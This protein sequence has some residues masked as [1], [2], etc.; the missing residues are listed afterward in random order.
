MVTPSEHLALAV[1]RQAVSDVFSKSLAGAA[2]D[3][4]GIERLRALRFLTAEHGVW[5]DDRRFW[6]HLADVDPEALRR[7]IVDVLEGHRDIKLPNEQ[8]AYR[9]NGH[10]LARALWAREKEPVAT[11]ERPRVRSVSQ[12]PPRPFAPEQPVEELIL[13]ALRNGRETVREVGFDVPSAVIRETL[14]A[15]VARGLVEK[16]GPR[17]RLVPKTPQSPPASV[18]LDAIPTT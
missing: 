18:L 12:P 2:D 3:A 7:N 11:T 13:D 16:D 10:D 6:C 4:Q 14:D 5:A 17:Y 15:L 8:I 9:L 1:I